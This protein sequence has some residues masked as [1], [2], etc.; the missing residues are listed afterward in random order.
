MLH[1]TL[2]GLAC[3]AA[4]SHDHPQTTPTKPAGP[5][6]SAAAAD[7]VGFLPADADLVVGINLGQVQQ[8]P[9]FKQFAPMFMDKV[10]AMLEKFKSWCD[11]DPLTIQSVA[12][13]IRHLGTDDQDGVV[14]VRGIDKAKL[15]GQCLAKVKEAVA[16]Q[17]T[18]LAVDGDVITIKNDKQV[19]VSSFVNDTTM[20]TVIGKGDRAGLD[21]ALAAGAALRGSPVFAEMIGKVKTTDSVW[22][23]AN[24][25][26]K[27]FEKLAQNGL[28][29]KAVFG[30]VNAAEG[31][32]ADVRMRVDSPEQATQLAGMGKS[33][34]G[35][36]EA[37]VDKLDITSEGPDVHLSVAMS[38]AKLQQVIGMLQSLGMGG[39][40]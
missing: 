36:A 26:S 29:A 19:S 8:S 23:V 12:L 24:G 9:L 28:K 38:G 3:V 35:Q 13:G 16:G 1:R 34:A 2:L 10:G 5:D 22:A 25:N 31:L 21:G 7:P 17:G 18:Q 37:F 20:V 39:G 32:T 27:A 6:Y 30:S 15:M 4:C 11:F 14:V 40:D 33:Q